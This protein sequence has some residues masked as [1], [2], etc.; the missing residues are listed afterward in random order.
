[1]ALV[2]VYQHSVTSLNVGNFSAEEFCML[3]IRLNAVVQRV[4][5][6]TLELVFP[7]ITAVV[8]QQHVERRRSKDRHVERRRLHSDHVP[9]GPGQVW[10]GDTG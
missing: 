3:F 7:P 6:F 1:M 4:L 8:V 2:C 9:P 10:H 5:S